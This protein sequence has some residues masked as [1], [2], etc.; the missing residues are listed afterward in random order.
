MFRYIAV[1]GG[2]F[3]LLLWAGPWI[4]KAAQRVMKKQDELYD[5]AETLISG[6]KIITDGKVH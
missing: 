5:M 2:L 4:T 6:K 1:G 3:L